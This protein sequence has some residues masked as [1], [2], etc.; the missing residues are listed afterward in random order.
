MRRKNA[1][2]LNNDINP[3]WEFRGRAVSVGRLARLMSFPL[4]I[5]STSPGSA[6]ANYRIAMLKTCITISTGQNI[7]SATGS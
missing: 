3:D 4:I 1:K 2:I 6:K 5:F 7:M